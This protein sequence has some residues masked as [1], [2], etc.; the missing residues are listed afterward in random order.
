MSPKIVYI[1]EKINGFFIIQPDAFT[2]ARGENFE[3]F[4]EGVYSKLLGLELH[5]PVD[6]CARSSKNVLRGLHGDNKNWKL[7]EALHGSVFF[8]AVDL[9]P[10]SSTF[11]G[12]EEIVLSS[13]NRLQVIL[14]PG[15]VNGHCVTSDEALFH[16][17]L[18]YGFTSQADQLSM[19]WNDP[20]LGILWPTQ[21]PIL[22]ERDK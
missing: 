9:N 12:R 18:S 4:N 17:R 7:I 8:A 14:P 21:T 1:S 15:C 19:K 13:A 22:S 10:D 3:A 5:F 6:S 16:Y 20:S 11:W 2:D